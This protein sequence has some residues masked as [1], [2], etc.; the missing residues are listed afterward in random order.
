MANLVVVR[1]QY[2]G[3]TTSI[4]L[5]NNSMHWTGQKRKDLGQKKDSG[6]TS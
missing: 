3:E 5:A 4:G 6:Y 2:G 1:R